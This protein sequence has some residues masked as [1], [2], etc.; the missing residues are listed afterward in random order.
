M[1]RCLKPENAERVLVFCC[2]V[3]V[4]RL[5]SLQAENATLSYRHI[6]SLLVLAPLKVET[7]SVSNILKC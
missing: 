1:G 7:A 2:I 4:I 3:R 6:D 5:L